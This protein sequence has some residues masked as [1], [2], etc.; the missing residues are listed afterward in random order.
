MNF[1][2]KSIDIGTRAST[3]YKKLDTSFPLFEINILE[4]S[5]SQLIQISREKHL[6]L[7]LDEMKRIQEYFLRA[8]RN[9]TDIE[10]E[11]I[12]QSWS[13]HCSYKT[14]KPVM[15]ETFLKV[16]SPEAL[17]A[18]SEDAAV[19][20]FDNEHSYVVKIESH[21]HPSALD[22][23]GGAS[24]GVGGILRDIMCMGAQP[25]AVVDPLFFGPLDLKQKDLPEGIKHPLYLLRG[26]V[27][28]ISNYGNSVGIPNAGGMV[29]FDEA[30]TGNCLVNVGCVGIMKNKNLVHSRVG[31]AGDVFVLVGGSTG[32][33]G[34]HGV[35][36]A[37]VEL[38][39]ESDSESRPAVQLGDPI[40]KEPL[41]HACLE[42]NE[43]GLLTGL[44]DLG[45]GGLSCV[46]GEMAHAAGLGAEVDMEKVHLREKDMSPWEIW[47]SE[48]QERMM[49]T[50]KPQDVYKVLE[51]FEFWGLPAS[52]IGKAI[53]GNRLMIKYKGYKIYDME[54]PFVIEAK[55]YARPFVKIPESPTIELNVKQPKDL[56][57]ALLKTL[58][59]FNIASKAWII[60]QYDSSVRGNTA[61]FPLQ[62]NFETPGHGDAAILR[63]VEDSYKGLAIT[64]DVNPRFCKLDPYWGAA[65]SVEESFRNIVSVGA[66]P[67]TMVD[68]LNFANPEKPENMGALWGCAEGMHFAAAEFNVP[69]V[70]GNV[71]LYNES[72]AGP[73]LPTPTIMTLGIIEDV[74]NSV[75]ADVKAADNFLYLIG[76]TFNE[77]GG[78]EYFRQVHNEWGKVVP[79]V[80]PEKTKAKMSALLKANSQ[81]LIASCHDLSE[82]GLAV[83]LA[84]MLTSGGFGAE[85]SIKKLDGR[86][87]QTANRRPDYKLFSESNGRWLT[88][89]KPEN[90]GRFEEILRQ[91]NVS[92]AKIGKTTKKPRLK[93]D[94]LIDLGL[95][96]LYKTWREPI[97]RIVEG[98]GST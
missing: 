17:V 11:S 19:V 2:L 31:N 25:I 69:F 74:R 78:S 21:N 23:F 71:S 80:H 8:K 81:K 45:G 3:L 57:A 61:L 4:A 85:I 12:A 36:F 95:K 39:A 34:I 47:V 7:S 55:E 32:R 88:E 83:A 76:E 63:P 18:V 86:K 29:Y 30:Y 22:P 38:T 33:D 82:G 43:K 93:I 90:S 79:R 24:T 44:K 73:I 42:A 15:R 58:G 66:T 52:I 54:L 91:Y 89:V 16:K 27:K 84:E 87:P 26:A 92:F 10:L 98:K 40:T 67:H 56:E 37:S 96:E 35:T 94:N 50:C 48:S 77:L 53:R 14:S 72:H 13:E 62:G 20:K 5:D 6:S 64:T 28:G 41:I 65:S 60:R 97:Y 59:S 70:S 1:K 51:I 75:S 49:L 68:C 46:V 9:P